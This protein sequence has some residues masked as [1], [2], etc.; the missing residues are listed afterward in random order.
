MA[1]L[2][3]ILV[4]PSHSCPS[5]SHESSSTGE[6]S[7]DVHKDNNG[8]KYLFLVLAVIVRTPINAHESKPHNAPPTK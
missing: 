8:W 5:Q 4:I 3:A 7:C 1:A 2:V 6:I